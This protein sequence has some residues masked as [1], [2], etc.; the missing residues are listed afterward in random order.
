M[1][2]VEYR[3]HA[4]ECLQLAGQAT[5]PQHKIALLDMADA[6]LRLARRAEKNLHA[7]RVH[8][9]PSPSNPASMQ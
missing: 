1:P 2:K 7:N 6:W 8:E 4:A 3:R 9:R 5:D